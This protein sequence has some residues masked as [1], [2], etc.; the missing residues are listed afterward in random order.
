MQQKI[1]YFQFSFDFTWY[2]LKQS[3]ESTNSKVKKQKKRSNDTR[4]CLRSNCPTIMEMT[5]PLGGR[6]RD[7]MFVNLYRDGNI[8]Q[9]FMEYSC[10]SDVLNKPCRFISHRKFKSKCIQLYSY[11]YALVQ[12]SQNYLYF[13]IFLNFIVRSKFFL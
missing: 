9:R 5:E 6:N 8:T 11:T 12:V 7:G 10:R 4:S 13:K 2:S 1:K 3:E